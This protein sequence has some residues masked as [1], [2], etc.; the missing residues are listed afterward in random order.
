[1]AKVDTDNLNTHSSQTLSQTLV[2]LILPR[3]TGYK[4]NGFRYLYHRRGHFSEGKETAWSPISMLLFL[5]GSGSSTTTAL[6]MHQILYQ[7][8]QTQDLLLARGV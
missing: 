6:N 3:T 1:M 7:T 4:E 2:L 8:L 5:T